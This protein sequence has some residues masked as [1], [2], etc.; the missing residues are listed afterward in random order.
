MRPGR[1]GMV[2]RQAFEGLVEDD[3]V[4]ALLLETGQDLVQGHPDAIA[5]ALAGVAA[6]GVLDQ[7]LAHRLGGGGEE[8]AAV[9]EVGEGVAVDSRSSRNVE[10]QAGQT[11]SA[12]VRPTS[13][14][15]LRQ[16]GQRM[17]MS[18]PRKPNSPGRRP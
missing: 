15:G 3:H 18:R 16:C 11:T 13:S 6:P 8:V 2:L 10:P 17:W 12:A 7:D 1:P 14:I 5:L 4:Q 9:G